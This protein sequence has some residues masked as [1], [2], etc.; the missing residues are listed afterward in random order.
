MSTKDIAMN[1]IDMMNEEQLKS[2]VNLFQAIVPNVPNNETLDAMEESEN[3]LKN[4]NAQKFY[5]VEELF[6]DLRS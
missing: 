2:F 1:I 3:L 5:S 4:P 6:E